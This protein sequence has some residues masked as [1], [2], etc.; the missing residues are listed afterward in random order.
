METEQETDLPDPV[1]AA[2]HS[3]MGNRYLY[4]YQRLVVANVL[5]AAEAHG[6]P[7]RWPAGEAASAAELGAA[8]AAALASGEVEER[9]DRGEARALGRQIVILPTGAG[10]SLCF[11]LPALLIDRPTLVIFPILALMQDQHRRMLERGF[12]ADVLRGGQEP[13][14]REKLW[15]R[16]DEGEVRLLIANPEVL[17]TDAVMRRLETARFA[18]LVIDE[19]HCVSEWGESFRPSYLRIAEIVEKTKAPLVSA[20]TAT[21]SPPV[22]EKIER[23][24]FGAEGARRVIGN[25]DRPNIRYATVGTLLRD[26]MAVRLAREQ[27]RPAIIFCSSRVATETLSRRLRA[28]IPEAETKFYHAGLERPEKTDV[29]RWF[30][31]SQ[32]GILAATCAYGMGV[33]KPNI[34]TVIHRDCPPS[35]E[36]YLQE[37]GRAGRDHAPSRAFLLW[38]PEDDSARARASTA[39]DRE[40]L[41]LL[42]AYARNPVG[43]RRKRLLRMLGAEHEYCSGCDV[44]EGAALSDYRERAPV[45]GFTRRNRRRYT[46]RETAAL[47]VSLRPE[48]WS[49]EEA[50]LV[51]ARLVEEKTLRLTT[52]PFRWGTLVPG[53]TPRRR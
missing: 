18:H 39:A 27:A 31:D 35:V 25:P 16:L 23:F 29:E 41:D 5:E 38:G 22:L 46:P 14:E 19:A 52:G 51:I 34:R 33:D 26:R 42:L 3:L 2:A 4:P 40:R 32:D 36:A 10:K 11:Q 48:D 53:P 43:C 47:L 24:V 15:K 13:Q 20:F 30:F 28:E 45:L 1:S 17:L 8:A 49:E 21:A 12:P 44:C 9:D 50:S 6:L 37:S 7:I